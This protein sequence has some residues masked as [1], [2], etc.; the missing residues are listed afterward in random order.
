M[1][2]SLESL[3][4]RGDLTIS[5]LEGGVKEADTGVLMSSFLLWT[6]GAQSAGDS[7]TVLKQALSC[8]SGAGMAGDLVPAPVCHGHQLPSMCPGTVTA[9]AVV[10]HWVLHADDP[11][12]VWDHCA[13]TCQARSGQGAAVQGLRAC[14]PTL[15]LPPEMPTVL[16]CILVLP[17]FGG[18]AEGGRSGHP[19]CE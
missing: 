13:P 9:V 6:V 19:G 10:W 14:A 3:T 18:P 7:G 4:N 1:A 12:R 16:C 8:P 15:P 5:G 11:G 17:W 2:V